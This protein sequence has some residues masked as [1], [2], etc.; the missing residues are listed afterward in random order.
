MR[1]MPSLYNIVVRYMCLRWRLDGCGAI[2]TI[3]ICNTIPIDRLFRA[4]M[5]RHRSVGID[6]RQRVPNKVSTWTPN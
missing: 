5:P 2:Q 3:G 1:R 6:V 4:R